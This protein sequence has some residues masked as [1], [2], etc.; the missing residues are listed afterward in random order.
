V[1]IN[2]E[3]RRLGW[4]GADMGALFDVDPDRDLHTAV[5]EKKHGLVIA[6]TKRMQL[7]SWIE[8]GIIQAYAGYTEK[9]VRYVNETF[10]HPA[11]PWMIYSP[12][13]L[14]EDEKRVV[15]A[16]FIAWDQRR[17]WGPRSGDIPERVQLQMW[18]YMA[19]LDYPVADVAALLG[20]ELRIYSIYRDLEVERVIL[21]RAE[22]CY[23]KY[24][25]GDEMPPIGS[26]VHAT[27]WL[28]QAF[29][30]HK[31]PDMRE[32]TEDEIA[33]MRRYAVVRNQFKKIEREKNGLANKLR[34]AVATREGIRW[35]GG[36]FTWRKTKDSEYVDYKSMAVALLYNYVKDE[37][38][39]KKMYDDY[40]KTKAGYRRIY[41]ECEEY[42]DAFGD[43]EFGDAAA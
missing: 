15:D 20:D 39:R 2:R 6:P 12:D 3:L 9:P 22:E 35:S 28:Q 13:A 18:W 42:A 41:F 30:A 25:E 27:A 29:P 23:R 26:S 4:G 14:R 11:R 7:G 8:P 19:A 34:E 21:A 1:A 24:L 31:R 37:E 36:K 32:A 10:Q 40:T 43:E 5:L 38:T 16:K 33:T 17:K